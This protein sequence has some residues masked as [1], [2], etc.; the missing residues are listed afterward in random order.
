MQVYRWACQALA[1]PPDH[2][3]LPLVWQKFLQLYLRQPGPEYG[4]AYLFLLTGA[5]GMV[6][7]KISCHHV[8]T[9]VC[10]PLGWLQVDALAEGSSKP[11]LR[12]L[13]SGSFDRKSRRCLTFTMLPARLSGYLRHTHLHLT[14]RETQVLTI[15]SSLIWPHHSCTQSWSGIFNTLYSPSW[16]TLSAFSAL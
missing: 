2:P 5:M 1:T 6:Q 13:C 11:L 7:K 3:L 4:Y 14:A 8:C 15:L 10:R 9:D 12:L 16:Q